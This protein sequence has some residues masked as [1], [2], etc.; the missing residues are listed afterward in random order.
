MSQGKQ[1]LLKVALSFKGKREEHKC[2]N[3]GHFGLVSVLRKAEAQGWM[4]A[5]VLAAS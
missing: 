4:Q 2:R 1:S 3:E 5:A